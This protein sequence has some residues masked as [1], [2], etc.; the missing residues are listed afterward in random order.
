MSIL[1]NYVTPTET[2]SNILNFL[3]NIDRTKDL[4][5]DF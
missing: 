2:Q 5:Y 1:S 3:N 4:F